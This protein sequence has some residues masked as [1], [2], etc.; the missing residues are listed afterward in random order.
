MSVMSFFDEVLSSVYS[1]WTRYFDFEGRSSRSEYWHWQ[2]FRILIFFS[3]YYL[4]S[5]TF[6]GLNFVLGTILLIPE[7]AVSIRRLHDTN[8]SGWWIL[9]NF[10]IFFTLLSPALLLFSI[11]G[12]STLIYF[13][14]LQGDN[15]TNDYGN[16]QS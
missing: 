15:H 5:V 12:I 13:Y 10:S 8:R 2:L 3:F 6:F 4:E 1:C 14:C 7:V 11:I 16:Q 9:L